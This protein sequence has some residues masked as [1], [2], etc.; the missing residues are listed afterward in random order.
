[1]TAA[2]QRNLA[3]LAIYPLPVPWMTTFVRGIMDYANGMGLGYDEP[4]LIGAGESP[5]AGSIRGWKGDGAIAAI[6]NERDI[7]AARRLLPG[8]QQRRRFVKRLSRVRPI[9]MPW[10]AGSR[11]FIGSGLR[12]RLLW[13]GRLL[14]Q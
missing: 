7:E 1:M 11:A 6:L 5:H 13:H 9:T 14:V 10:T 4:P 8:S 12:A 2:L 3:K